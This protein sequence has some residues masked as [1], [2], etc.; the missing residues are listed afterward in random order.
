MQTIEPGPIPVMSLYESQGAIIHQHL[1]FYIS[2]KAIHECFLR[3]TS[4][5][6]VRFPNIFFMFSVRIKSYITFDSC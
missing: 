6:N 1:G 5:K 4:Y 2:F 3:I